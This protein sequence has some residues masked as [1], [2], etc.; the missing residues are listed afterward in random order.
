M[1]QDIDRGVADLQGR[2][3]LPRKNGELVFKHPWEGRVF[4]LTLALRARRPYPWRGFRDR[5]EREIATAEDGDAGLHY[6]EWWTRAF[7]SVL[8]E[9]GI[10]SR[11][12]LTRRTW[13]YRRGLRDEVF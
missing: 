1:T 9:E 11:E 3:A 8:V 2:T 4:G 13:E 10:V 7:E 12:E 6:Y 5:L